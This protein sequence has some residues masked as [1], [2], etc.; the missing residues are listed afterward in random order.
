MRR[1][2]LFSAFCFVAFLLAVSI[3]H[4]QYWFQIGARSDSSSSNN[5]GASVEIETVFP[6]D[7]TT[8]SMG[9]WVGE[10]LPNGAFA[11]VGYI[12]ENQT[13]KYPVNCTINE[14]SSNEYLTAGK[15][16]WFYEYFLSGESQDFLGSV[17]PDGSAG[18]NGQF[19]KY[20]FYSLG[21]TWYFLF[22]NKTIGSVDLGT[23]D[24][25]PYSPI[26]VGELA[27]TTNTNTRMNAVVFANLSVYKH[28][29]SLP[30]SSGYGVINYGVGSKTGLK[31]PYGV[32]E[33][34]NRVNYFEVGSGLPQSTNN[35]KLWSLGYQLKV[36][37]KYGNLTSG[38][39][40]VAYS[41]VR[42]SAPKLIY[43][44]N[45]SRAAFTG[46]SGKGIGSYTGALNNTTI[47]MDNNI[48]ET[49]NWQ[50]QYFVN[51]SSLYGNATGTGWYANGSTSL[52][53]I[54]NSTYQNGAERFRFSHWS[55]N[56]QNLNGSILVSAPVNLSAVWQY[57][58]LLVGRNAYDEA[59]NISSFSID[60]YRTNSTPFL[61]VGAAHILQGAYY[62]GLL[63]NANYT[64]TQNASPT[65]YFSLPVYNITIRVNDLFYMPVNASAMLSYDNG[66]QTALFS[67]SSGTINIPN[68]PYGYANATLE[69]LGIRS[70]AMVRN[71]AA[72]AVLF[73]SPLNI[74]TILAIVII[75]A[76]V[77]FRRRS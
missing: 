20:S 22:N 16:E 42:I 40:Y 60:G 75:L 9:F 29:L 44:S 32:Q 69:Y 57:R 58:V 38:N 45:V 5:N 65:F 10:N 18:N 19:N 43:L 39:T 7:L 76:Y 77:A 12:I 55:N 21:N 23:S 46:W 26:A 49:A 1:Y 28:N 47:T 30:I 50:L 15:A 25:G 17:G 6:Q 51:V 31:N 24:S 74:A 67:G 68:V 54:N 63:L 62:K 35:T 14:C 37:S 71:G 33:L 64:I 59:L 52:Y 3:A 34:G 11:Q 36:M 72:S 61:N 53:S 41:T 27:N 56:N 66:T 73:I 70:K 4:A 8:G 48:T 2:E 13:G